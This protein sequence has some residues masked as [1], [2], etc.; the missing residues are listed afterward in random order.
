MLI[1]T[2]RLFPNH[3][4]IL[5]LCDMNKVKTEH[6]LNAQIDQQSLIKAPGLTISGLPVH[7]RYR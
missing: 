3:I 7:H 6:S 2:S 5:F 1:D 4:D